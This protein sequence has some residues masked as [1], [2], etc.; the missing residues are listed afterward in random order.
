MSW[1]EIPLPVD[2]RLV[3]QNLVNQFQPNFPKTIVFKAPVRLFDALTT[4]LDHQMLYVTCMV[5]KQG[6]NR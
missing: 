3:Q 1:G 4:K 5:N 2:P 6:A